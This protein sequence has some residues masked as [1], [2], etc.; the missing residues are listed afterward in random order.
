MKSPDGL[1]VGAELTETMPKRLGS[2]RLAEQSRI[3][4]KNQHRLHREEEKPQITQKGIN[5][6]RCAR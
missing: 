2:E 6:M 1:L 4:I 3:I 5:L